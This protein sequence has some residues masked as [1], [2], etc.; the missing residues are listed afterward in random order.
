MKTK[1]EFLVICFL[2]DF[3]V[4]FLF[5]GICSVL[6]GVINP[7]LLSLSQ[8]LNKSCFIRTIIARLFIEVKRAIAF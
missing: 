7:F 4:F 2:T 1:T 8:P 5:C 6:S 3:S